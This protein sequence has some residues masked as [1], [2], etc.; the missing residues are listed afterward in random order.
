MEQNVSEKAQWVERWLSRCSANYVS[1]G[2]AV[3]NP[4]PMLGELD[5]EGCVCTLSVVVR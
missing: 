5:S 3:W 4:E 2:I 1:K